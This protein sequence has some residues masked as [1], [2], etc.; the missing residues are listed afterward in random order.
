M[1]LTLPC[2]REATC[3]TLNPKVFTANWKTLNGKDRKNYSSRNHK[4]L[5]IELDLHL[6]TFRGHLFLFLGEKKYGV[7]WTGNKWK[8]KFMMFNSNSKSF[9]NKVNDHLVIKFFHLKGR[10]TILGSAPIT[11]IHQ[12]EQIK[13]PALIPKYLSPPL[14]RTN[15]YF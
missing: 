2:G 1:Y 4:V 14:Q 7:Q 11:F 9:F 12:F 13:Q 5:N 3:K 8:I 15:I 10:S 6:K